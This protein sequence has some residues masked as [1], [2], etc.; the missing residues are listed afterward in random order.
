MRT[1]SLMFAAAVLLVVG[2]RPTAPRDTAPPAPP[3]GV[4]SV[5]GDGEVWVHWLPNQEGDLAGYRV[6]EGPCSD[7]P[8][9]PYELVGGTTD[10]TFRVGGLANGE[11]RFFAV[12]AFDYAGNESALSYENVFDTPRP[13]GFGLGLSNAFN[14]PERSGW[15]FSTYRVLPIDHADTDIFFASDGGSSKILTAYTD[16]DIQDAGYT[17]SLDEVD[18]APAG[19]WSPTGAVEAI[20]GHSYVVWT[21]DNHFAKLRVVSLSP[22]R[23]VVDWAYQVARGNP[24]LSARPAR[25]EG[26]PRVPRAHGGMPR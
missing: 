19:G 10:I 25:A 4:L 20:P 15:D 18:W 8:G 26:Q 13:E 23:L 2:C 7:G 14:D 22:S 12:A 5:T 9:C 11:T 3:R 1:R 16:T 17:E 21:H 24:E 6:Y